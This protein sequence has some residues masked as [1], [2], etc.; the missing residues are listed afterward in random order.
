MIGRTVA[1]LIVSGVAI[2]RFGFASSF[3]QPSTSL[4]SSTCPARTS[5]ALND[6]K[7]STNIVEDEK[8]KRLYDPTA[9][10]ASYGSNMAQY[11]V[12]LHD[13]KATFDFCGG[14]MFQLI[15]SDK[16]RDHLGNVAASSKDDEQ[17][18]PVVYDKI[19]RMNGI[20]GYTKSAAADNVRTF[21]GR[22]VRQ[23]KDAT[24]GMGFA[25]HLSMANSDDPEGWTTEE[26]NDYDGWGHDVNRTWR[27]GDRLQK[28]GF[29]T[30]KSKFG[31]D[32][33]GLHHKF[34]LH[35]DYDNKFW[36]SAE[37]GCEGTPAN[38]NQK[39]GFK[40]PF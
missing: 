30:Y 37:D 6:A 38:P 27:N 11:L 33:F 10:D 24:G 5:T 17:Q 15:L 34:Y 9:R 28:E 13:S 26:I 1:S 19:L 35:T 21:H 25:I 18:Q 12:D 8:E 7:M 23:V 40:W 36:L 2:G 3:N 14:M 4:L 20:P 29:T 32:A 31:N 22:E 16:L 39:R